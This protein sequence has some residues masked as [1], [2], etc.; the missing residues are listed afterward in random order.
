MVDVTGEVLADA[1]AEI[2]RLRQALDAIRRAYDPKGG[3]TAECA[4]CNV[5][6]ADCDCGYVEASDDVAAFVA[7][8]LQIPTTAAD[9]QTGDLRIHAWFVASVDAT[10]G[11][12]KRHSTRTWGFFLSPEEAADYVRNHVSLLSENRYYTHAIVEEWRVAD[13]HGIALSERWWKLEPGKHLPIRERGPDYVE[14]TDACVECDKPARFENTR[15][16]CLG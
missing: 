6:D 13:L 1:M 8:T 14:P 5:E 15:N 9:G 3:C 10:E 2:E 12:E 7:E 16:F 11:K 4:T